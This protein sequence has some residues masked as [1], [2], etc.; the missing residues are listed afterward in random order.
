MKSLELTVERSNIVDVDDNTNFEI[1]CR[2]NIVKNEV[3][4]EIEMLLMIRKILKLPGWH[5][6]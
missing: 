5:I 4:V 2:A 6:L 1:V 3:I